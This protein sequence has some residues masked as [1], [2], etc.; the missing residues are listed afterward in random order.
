VDHYF[1][2][3]MDFAFRR[4]GDAARG[5]EAEEHVGAILNGLSSDCVVLHDVP[6]QFG[7]IDHL[8]FRHDGAIF[9]IETKSHR[10]RVTEQS[11]AKFVQQTLRNI[12]WLRDV[13]KSRFG[14]EPWIH[15][16]IVFTKGYVRLHWTIQRV[17]VIRP[18]YLARWMAKQPGNSPLAERLLPRIE[19]VKKELQSPRELPVA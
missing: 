11:A 17:A 10:G 6:A 5:A 3:W 16:A 1:I 8:V 19:R 9:L 7:N 2:G 4:E 14:I 18:S 13:L 15:A 12:L